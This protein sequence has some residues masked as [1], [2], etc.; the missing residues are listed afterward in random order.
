MDVLSKLLYIAPPPPKKKNL[1]QVDFQKNN[2]FY[3]KREN[4]NL[5]QGKIPAPPWISNGPSLIVLSFV[6][7][8]MQTT[9]VLMANYRA[10]YITLE[11]W[12]K[13]CQLNVNLS[14]ASM[15]HSVK[16]NAS[17]L[18][19]NLTRFGNGK[20]VRIV[21]HYEYLGVYLDEHLVDLRLHQPVKNSISD[22]SYILWNSP[23]LGINSRYRLP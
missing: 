8:Y 4:N 6:F 22:N 18:N 20:D 7:F 5:S 15:V 3:K 1:Y 11:T 23:F 19:T 10:Y 9:W 17:K 21:N 2:L 14:K 16:I 13:H 12:C